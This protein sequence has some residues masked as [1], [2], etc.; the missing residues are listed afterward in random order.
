M[1]STKELGIRVREARRQRSKKSGEDFSQR[2]L[3]YKIGETTK[4]VRRLESGEFYPDWD[5]LNFIADVCGV[6][7]E[8]LTGESFEDEIEYEEATQGGRV[9]GRISEDQLRV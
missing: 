6:D 1:Y 5:A 9:A 4:W 3:A 2:K 8:Y 7:I